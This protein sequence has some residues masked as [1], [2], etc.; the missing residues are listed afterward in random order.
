M[1]QSSGVK[2]IL[3]SVLGAAV[4]AGGGS[5]ILLGA[6]KADKEDLGEHIEK[7]A[8]LEQRIVNERIYNRLGN[9]ETGQQVMQRSLEALPAAI[10][11]E[12]KK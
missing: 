1:A 11:K 2:N 5:Y 10:V 7:P 9:L 6:S 3:L 12:M 4:I 8:H